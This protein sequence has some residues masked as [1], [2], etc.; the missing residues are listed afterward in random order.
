MTRP[1]LAEI[2]V[3]AGLAEALIAEQFPALHPTHAEPFA[4]GWDN[5][6]FLVNGEY[7]FRFP[8]RQLGA[9][10]LATENNVLPHIADRLPLAAPCPT[11]I[12]VPTERF[13]WPFAGYRLLPGTTACRARLDDRQ[14]ELIAAP[15]GRFLR[16]L[17]TIDA[18]EG[19][20]FGAPPDE[21]GR[22]NLQRRIP[23]ASEHLDRLAAAGVDFDVASLRRVLSHSSTCRA[24]V[25]TCL[26]HGD[27]Y[28]R[29]LIV[30][31]TGRLTGVIDWGDVH[32]GNRAVDLAIAHG[33]LPP[34]LHGV[35]RNAYGAID[36]PTWQLARFR[37]L[38]HAAVTAV[39]GHDI[40]DTDLLRESLTALQ[41]IA[42]SIDS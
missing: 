32:V 18:E 21:L 20:R 17:H 39:Y 35:F 33:V 40:G 8:R 41:F 19:R 6:A 14:R 31:A 4:V 28:I 3:T 15:L 34:R 5:T 1:W 29:H 36:E 22:L 27:L 11:M 13:N 38:Q 16:A 12:G 10:C 24:A 42:D 30:D 23:Q 2:E 26:V 7:I 37:A 9:D 25:A